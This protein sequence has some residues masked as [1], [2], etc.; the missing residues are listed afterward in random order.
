MAIVTNAQAEKA[1]P[2]VRN[3]PPMTFST[4]VMRNTALSRDHARSAKE[5]PMATMKVT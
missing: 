2:A 1:I 5:D 4:P 3:H